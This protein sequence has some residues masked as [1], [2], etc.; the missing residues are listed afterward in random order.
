MLIVTIARALTPIGS[1]RRK[2]LRLYTGHGN[3]LILQSGFK[4]NSHPMA[5]Y[6]N[7]ITLKP[8]SITNQQNIS[9]NLLASK[10]NKRIFAVPKK[11]GYINILII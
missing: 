9:V 4:K 3:S 1:R 7:C 11:R 8:Y 10:G 6:F 5:Q 2:A